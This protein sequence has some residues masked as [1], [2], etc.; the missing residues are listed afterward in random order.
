MRTTET[1]P[2]NLRKFPSNH[3]KICSYVKEVYLTP[4]LEVIIS[5]VHL[6]P[7]IGGVG[8]TLSV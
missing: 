7:Q 1:S 6:T 4:F 5:K 2:E 8:W 3:P